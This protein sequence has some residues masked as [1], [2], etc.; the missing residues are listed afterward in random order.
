MIIELPLLNRIE[1]YK[2][3][4]PYLKD[5][6]KPENI[7]IYGHNCDFIMDSGKYETGFELDNIKYYNDLGYK[8]ALVASKNNFDLSKF[9]DSD[10]KLLETLNQ[11]KNKII[12][13]SD[14]FNDYIHL[15]YLNLSTILS[16][17]RT[18][19]NCFN[20]QIQNIYDEIVTDFSDIEYYDTNKLIV[21]YIYTCGKGYCRCAHNLIC[22]L[23]NRYRFPC[24]NPKPFQSLSQGQIIECLRRNIQSFKLEFI[25]MC[26]FEVALRLL[27]DTYKTY[28]NQGEIRCLK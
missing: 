5:N 16:V 15:N 20:K 17:L 13:T 12:I 24:P 9:K 2:K 8:V 25:D 22:E 28:T 10:F 26:N 23:N 1:Y 27:I 18:S 14:K 6:L 11:S 7:V 21:L 3:L 4:E 19:K